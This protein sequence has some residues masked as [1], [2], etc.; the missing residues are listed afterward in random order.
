MHALQRAVQELLC[1]ALDDEK[2][3]VPGKAGDAGSVF[4]SVAALAWSWPQPSRAAS[5]RHSGAACCRWN[6]YTPLELAAIARRVAEQSRP[7]RLPGGQRAGR[8]A[9]ADATAHRA[10]SRM[11][12]RFFPGHTHLGC[13]S[14]RSCSGTRAL[15]AQGLGPW[16]RRY[17]RILAASPRHTASMQRLAKAIGVDDR[18][19]IGEEVEPLLL[20]LALVDIT[21]GNQRRLTPAGASRSG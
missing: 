11:N 1:Q 8:A 18:A 20:H 12:W 21:A 2:V 10:L 4:Q 3:P 9:A 19:S 16:H 7:A 15:T 13:V 6:S 14:Y 17:L 5:Y